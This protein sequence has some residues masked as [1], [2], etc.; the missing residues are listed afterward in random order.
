M[1]SIRELLTTLKN[2]IEESNNMS[3]SEALLSLS[4]FDKITYNE[5]DFIFNNII[6]EVLREKTPSNISLEDQK[7]LAIDFLMNGEKEESL[8]LLN[9]YINKL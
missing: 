4:S 2:T 3:I 5:F 6:R 7:N 9:N 1:K 8:K